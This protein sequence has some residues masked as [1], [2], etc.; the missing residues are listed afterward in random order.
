MNRVINF[1]GKYIFTDDKAPSK[2]N[3]LCEKMIQKLVQNVVVTVILIILSYLLFGASSLYVIIF[4]HNRVTLIGTEI[5][6]LPS[7][8]DFGYAMNMIQQLILTWV[9]LTANITIE[10]GDCL[11][12]NTVEVIPEIIH[13]ES[14]ELAKEMRLNGM[15]W[16]TKAQ[17]R[18]ILLRVQDFS[19]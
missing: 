11:T 10:I 3:T 16:R 8:T 19:G 18:G 7:D 2:Y 14:E 17:L 6:F 4:R 1:G 9:S 5:P 13:L 12:Q 15:S